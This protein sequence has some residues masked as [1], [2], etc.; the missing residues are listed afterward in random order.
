MAKSDKY[1]SGWAASLPNPIARTVLVNVVSDGQMGRAI[2][3]G[4]KHVFFGPT[5][6]RH[7]TEYLRAGLARHGPSGRAWAEGAA[8]Q[9]ARHGPILNI[10]FNTIGLKW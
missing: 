10:I 7:G 8:R 1:L 3:A 9:A 6:T 2:R 4:P 5:R